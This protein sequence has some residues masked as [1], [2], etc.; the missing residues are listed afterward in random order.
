MMHPYVP[1]LTDYLYNSVF[2]NKRR[3]VVLESIPQ[4]EPELLNPRLEVEYDS[5]WGLVS[6]ANSARM[7]AKVKR[8]W[9]LKTGFYSAKERLPPPA[10]RLLAEAAN[11]KAMKFRKAEALPIVL[12]VRLDTAA[13]GKRLKKD[14]DR[15]IAAVNASDPWTLW[16]AATT[17]GQV[18]I[19][20]DGKAFT[21]DRKEI[22]FEVKPQGGFAVARSG[23][24]FVALETTRDE[25]LVAEG[26]IRD[27]AR[28][29]QALRKE[30]G[31]VPT[32]VLPK[33]ELGGL[34]AATAELISSRRE[35]LLFLVRVKEVSV[36]E[37]P[38]EG[39]G[40]TESDLDGR[41]I[42]LRI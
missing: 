32:E 6:L 12:K 27:V 24:S 18:T 25:E 13:A 19:K 41:K 36:S 20:L 4:P 16:S 7:N 22:D 9:P 5:M 17:E 14:F 23:E 28:R 11:V 33:A 3:S 38:P 37:S 8:R 42:F 35:M 10:E 34:D 30:K 15:V 39:E 29:L 1:F 31:Y 40:W 26:T 21:F 2:S